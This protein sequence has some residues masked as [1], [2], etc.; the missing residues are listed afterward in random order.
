VASSI[1]SGNNSQRP[2]TIATQLR[3]TK[4]KRHQIGYND[5]TSFRIAIHLSAAQL[6]HS[7]TP[8]QID[9]LENATYSAIKKLGR[10]E[11]L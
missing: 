10:K 6:N 11:K 5:N 7:F 3:E 2:E 1:P 9:Q 4:K 8:E